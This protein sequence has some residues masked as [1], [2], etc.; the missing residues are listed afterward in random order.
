MLNWR[1]IFA[2]LSKEY[3]IKWRTILM[4]LSS[5]RFPASFPHDFMHLAF[6]NML[7]NLLLH[8]TLE[9]K[10]L[11]AGTGCYGLEKKV[12]EEI[13]V[14]TSKTGDTIPSAYGARVPD[15][16]KDRSTFTADNFC[17]WVVYI[18]PIE[19]HEKFTDVRYYN[20]F[21]KLVILI[22]TCLQYEY[23]KADIEKIR[24]GFAEWVVEY[25]Q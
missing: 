1:R 10:G 23:S 17:F 2:A 3:G 4:D 9:Y 5:L 18:A 8:W 20:H 16:S 6:E 19:L 25:E 12:W 22:S 24:K 21:I 7:K 13:G 15:I 14:Q 11:D